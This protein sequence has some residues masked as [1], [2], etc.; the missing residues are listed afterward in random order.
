M[1]LPT[2][3]TSVYCLL[4]GSGP[5]ALLFHSHTKCVPV[6]ESLPWISLL[7]TRCP[8]TTPTSFLS[9]RTQLKCHL[10]R[11]LSQQLFKNS[12]FS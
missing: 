5:L 4:A 9:S 6:S 8:Q 7:G 11:V 2:S 1:A 10:F 3:L 12:H